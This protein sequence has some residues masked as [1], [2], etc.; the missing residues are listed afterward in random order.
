MGFFSIQKLPEHKARAKEHWKIECGQEGGSNNN[1][2]RKPLH[3]YTLLCRPQ[4][5][6]QVSTESADE[7]LWGGFQ[8]IERSFNV[9]FLANASNP[10]P[11]PILT[12]TLQT[13]WFDLTHTDNADMIDNAT[14]PSPPP[15]KKK[16]K[17][18]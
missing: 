9:G 18:P 10:P 5:S 17:I 11:S 8:A 1:K 12:Y 15:Q 6:Y 7:G 3:P 4:L 16:K 13:Y 2:N 14:I